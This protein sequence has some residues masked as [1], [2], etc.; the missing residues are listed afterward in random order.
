MNF[1]GCSIVLEG[2]MLL[3]RAG[4][5]QPKVT[6]SSGSTLTMDVDGDTG[7]ES[8]ILGEGGAKSVDI[9]IQSG[10]TLDIQ[11][12]KVQDLYRTFSKSGLLVVESGG[13][14]SMTNA[15]EIVSSDIQALGSAYPIVRS[16]GGTVNINGGQISGVGNTGIGLSGIDAYISATGLTVSNAF[17]G[18][19]V[20]TQHY[21]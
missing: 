6:L 5:P 17:M 20:K 21:L 15:A 16:D 14:L 10:G 8:L 7:D 18:V 12:G 3:F 19:K 1:D 11:T 2:S 9:R 4:N 13:T